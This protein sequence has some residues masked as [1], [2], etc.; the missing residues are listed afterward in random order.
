MKHSALIPC[1]ALAAALIAAAGDKKK[2]DQDEEQTT[3][4]LQLPPDLPATR[5]AEAGRLVFQVTPLRGSGLLSQQLRE[6]LKPLLR[7]DRPLVKLRAFV[8]GTGDTRRV[9]A[10][11]SELCTEKDVP[12]PALTSIQVGELPLAG[13]Q[14]VLESVALEKKA[15]NPGGIVMVPAESDFEHQPLQPVLPHVRRVLDRLRTAMA[16]AGAGAD[17]VLQVTCYP[18]SLDEVD[19]FR[20]AV[21]DAFPKAVPDVV[22]PLR[23]AL[24]SGA[25]CEAVGRRMAQPPQ[26]A[27]TLIFTGAQLAFGTAP[28]DAR[29]AFER[30]GKT[31]AQAGS[32]YGRVVHITIY[33]MSRSTS[34]LAERAA[35]EF[36]D[37]AKPPALTAVAVEALP[38]LDASFAV[39][40]VAMLPA[41]K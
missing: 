25:T 37:P 34:E 32:S 17:D 40:A 20:A 39:D 36:F 4:A 41:S 18:T 8:A 10:V 38:S 2:H 29:L 7:K 33:S 27:G 35:R 26:G 1:L 14:I 22:Q 13:A 31:L 28:G 30:L 9:Q 19:P 5:S 6:A 16:A 23:A 21:A 24:E 11:V 15:V 3:Q 12:L